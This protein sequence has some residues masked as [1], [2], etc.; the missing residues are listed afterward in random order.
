MT[1]A[2][3]KLDSGVNITA[4]GA[5]NT[6]SVAADEGDWLLVAAETTSNSTTHL[7]T[8]SGLTWNVVKQGLFNTSDSL[9]WHKCKVPS[10][11]F[12]GV[13]TITP[14]AAIGQGHWCVLKVTGDADPDDL[15]VQNPAIYTGTGTTFTGALE[16]PRSA[17]SKSV[18]VAAHPVFQ[19]LGVNAETTELAD[20]P[21]N[22][23]AHSFIVGWSDADFEANL[24]FTAGTSGNWGFLVI[25]IGEAEE[26]EPEPEPEPE[27]EET[28]GSWQGLLNIY[29]E[30]QV[31]RAREMNEAPVACPY[32]GS[33]LDIRDGIR[34]CPMGDYRWTGYSW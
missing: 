12:S 14:S 33:V 15:I 28:T 6:L 3:T 24:G 4:T 27:P 18:A 32:D 25:E 19:G 31:N 16:E 17:N 29:R 20:H 9:S 11:G 23:P 1:I 30:A 13:L 21:G 7:V 22:S 26:V 5:F 34:N 2:L 10:G 8:G